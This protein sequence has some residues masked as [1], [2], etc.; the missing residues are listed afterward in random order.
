[1]SAALAE[2]GPVK[3]AP[4]TSQFPLVFPRIRDAE[5]TSRREGRPGWTGPW[6]VA[7]HA[8]HVQALCAWR[9][10]LVAGDT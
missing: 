9:E 10:G 5:E 1:M 8:T 2:R 4:L 3:A 6:P 7:V